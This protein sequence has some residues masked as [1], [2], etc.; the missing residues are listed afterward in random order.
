MGVELTA[1][2][3]PLL[4]PPEGAQPDPEFFNALSTEV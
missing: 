2:H 1:Q 3:S 4:L